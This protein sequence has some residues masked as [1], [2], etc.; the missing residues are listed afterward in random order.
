MNTLTIDI[1]NSETKVDSWDNNGFIRRENL[2][3]NSVEEI[4]RLVAGQDIK[5]VI[6]STVRGDSEEFIREIKGKAGC[7]CVVNFDYSEI[8][9]HYAD[10]IF[11]RGRIGADR[12]AAFLGAEVLFPHVSKLIIDAG[13]AITYDITDNVGNFCG[14]NI[15]LGLYS[16]MK[17]LAESTSMLPD[18]SDLS[19]NK[20]FGE[21]TFSAI[22]AGAV[23][24]VVGEVKYTIEK[25]KELYNIQQVV[26][27]G[28]GIGFLP[29][30]TATDS[31]LLNIDPFLVG[32]GLNYHF[33]KFYFPEVFQKTKFHQNL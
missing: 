20:V 21:D 5:G 25:A 11:Y 10:R 15:S 31:C 23:N 32:R 6:V 8:E 28:G 1:G 30:Y 17:T 13:T 7:K 12:V 2:E 9:N 4:R 29:V 16:R 24:G 27:T 26:A 19:S 22:Q 3:N 33:R 14:G 18:V